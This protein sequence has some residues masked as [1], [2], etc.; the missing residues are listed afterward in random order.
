MTAEGHDVITPFSGRVYWGGC[1]HPLRKV[2]K[3]VA[4]FLGMDDGATFGKFARLYLLPGQRRP[5]PRT[6]VN[7]IA[8]ARA[9]ADAH[10]LISPLRQGCSPQQES[11]GRIF[12]SIRVTCLRN[13][14]NSPPGPS[15]TRPSAG[16]M[17]HSSCGYRATDCCAVAVIGSSVFGFGSPPRR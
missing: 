9:F 13:T 11:A 15:R 16:E 3:L 7:P 14:P 1:S 6:P 2:H 8:S 4:A 17:Q 10:P 12:C 5:I